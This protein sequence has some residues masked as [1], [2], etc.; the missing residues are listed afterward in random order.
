MFGFFFFG[1]TTNYSHCPYRLVTFIS[2][3]QFFLLHFSLLNPLIDVHLS[4]FSSTIQLFQSAQQFT[5]PVTIFCKKIIICGYSFASATLKVLWRQNKLQYQSSR[6]SWRSILRR[7]SD[8]M[9]PN[10]SYQSLFCAISALR[11]FGPLSSLCESWSGGHT[12][13]VTD[14]DWSCGHVRTYLHG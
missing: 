10:L 2:S 6:S 1:E 9:L 5:E 13:E 7:F 12:V 11:F 3:S 8:F 14:I 4:W